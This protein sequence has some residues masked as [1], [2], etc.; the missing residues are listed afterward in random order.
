MAAENIKVKVNTGA[1]NVIIRDEFDEEI[2]SFKFIPSDLDIADRYEKA[3]A[4]FESIAISEDAEFDSFIE[5]SSKIKEIFDYL[6]NYKVSDTLFKVCNPLTPVSNGDFYF[7]VCIE[8]I[9]NII[10]DTFN[11]RLEKKKARIQKATSKYTKKK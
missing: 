2:G 1:I 3:I 9:A 7:E 6:L 5:I 11:K 10:E 4:E 8:T